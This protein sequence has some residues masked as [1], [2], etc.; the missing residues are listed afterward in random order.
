[1]LPYGIL[2]LSIAAFGLFLCERKPS[3]RKDAIFLGIVS[4][5]LILFAALRADTV[6]IDYPMYQTYF[7]RMHQEGWRF[8]IGPENEY[9]IEFSFSLLNYMVSLFSGDVRVLMAVMA[10]LMTAMAAAVL[11]RDC[12]IPWVGMFVFVS[13]NFFGNSMSFIR[14]SLAIGIFLFAIRYLKEKR[15]VPYLLILLLAASFHKSMLL[16][17]PFYFLAQLRV[18]W[19][20]VL[21]YV[22][23]AAVL[24]LLFWPIFTFVTQFVYQ[25][26]ATEEGLYFLRGRNWQT[27]FIPVTLAIVALLAQKFLL[28][29]SPQN[30]VLVNFALYTGLLFFMTCQHYIFQRIG[31]IFFASAIFLVPELLKS[32]RV[33]QTDQ[34]NL[35]EVKRIQGRSEKK[36]LLQ[37]RKKVKRFATYRQYYYNYSLGVTLLLGAL[38]YF[39]FLL[40]NRINLIP[41]VTFFS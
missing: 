19:K 2:L 41:Y 17:L 22:S 9:R 3:R 25:F 18:T 40:Q 16:L 37:E 29:R 12:S 28:E 39:W 32:I 31:N 27:A 11:Y 5:V 33:E 14:Q 6:G 20:S 35:A 13:F 10:V 8:L 15:F 38:Y 24:L 4:L 34:E 30:V 1:M 21:T 26:Y 7:E 23:A 36:K